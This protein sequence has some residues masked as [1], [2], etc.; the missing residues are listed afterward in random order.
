M[1]G[2]LSLVCRSCLVLA[3]M[4][5][6]L[7]IEKQDPMIFLKHIQSKVLTGTI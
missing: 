5:E 6:W 4:T 3:G 1:R 7:R 2:I